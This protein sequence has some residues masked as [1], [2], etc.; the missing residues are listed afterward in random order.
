MTHK[1]PAASK[2]ATVVRA[3]GT[4]GN[5]TPL[6]LKIPLAPKSTT[7][8][9]QPRDNDF[10]EEE[11]LSKRT[12]GLFKASNVARQLHYDDEAI[13]AEREE[14]SKNRLALKKAAEAQ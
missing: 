10:H 13:A 14:A 7:S 6:L 2:I 8:K 12:K 11:Q 5:E 4:R 9:K 3:V 1:V